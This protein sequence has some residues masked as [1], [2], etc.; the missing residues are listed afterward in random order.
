MTPIVSIVG[1]KNSGKTTLIEGVVSELVSRRWRIGTIK[2]SCHSLCLDDFDH[3][4]KDSYRHK[5]AGAEVVILSSPDKL[6][7][8][9]ETN[10]PSTDIRRYLGDID[11]ILTEGYKSG[12]KFKIE[13]CRKELGEELL[14]TKEK[15]N[16][17]AIVTDS[18]L[19]PN[20]P[21]F[22][23]DDYKGISDFLEKEF[24]VKKKQEEMELFVCQKRIPLNSFVKGFFKNSILG[25]IRSLRDVPEK[26]KEIEIR[27]D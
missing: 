18:D 22:R 5:A 17:V 10:S 6:M 11:L 4:G 8:I 15:D 1:R 21:C 25:M 26:P 24:I 7:L 2:H 14:C 16:L 27:I 13:I 3:K 20:L 12:D 23:P 9:K 19:N